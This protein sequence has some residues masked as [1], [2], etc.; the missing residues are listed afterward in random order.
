MVTRIPPLGSGAG[1]SGARG[2]GAR[3]S[4]VGRAR[5]GR[6]R[7]GCTRVGRA[8]V[9]RARGSGARGAGSPPMPPHARMTYFHSPNAREFKSTLTI[10]RYKLRFTDEIA[11]RCHGATKTHYGYTTPHSVLVQVDHSSCNLMIQALLEGQSRTSRS[12]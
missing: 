1:G 3:G 12:G 8:R 4:R 6:A 5:V 7:V 9:E 11:G 10:P 2:S